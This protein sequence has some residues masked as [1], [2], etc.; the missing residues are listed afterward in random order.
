VKQKK[1]SSRLEKFAW[2]SY[3]QPLVTVRLYI[4]SNDKIVIAIS[5]SLPH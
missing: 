1:T 3:L 4:R 5:H 2:M